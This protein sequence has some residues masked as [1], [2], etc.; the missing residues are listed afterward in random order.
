MVAHGERVVSRKSLPRRS[1]GTV[2]VA[3]LTNAAKFFAEIQ[4]IR[5]G[6]NTKCG[7]FW[8]SNL[9]ILKK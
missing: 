4:R 1:M 3:G 2:S 6:V 7:E 5:T 9:K 8:N